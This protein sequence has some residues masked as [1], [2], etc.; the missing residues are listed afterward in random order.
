MCR[1]ESRVVGR[2]RKRDTSV[3]RGVYLED[4]I[5]RGLH[6]GNRSFRKSS[7]GGVGV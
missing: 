4:R 7:L 2:P 6:P 3:S 1:G 5:S